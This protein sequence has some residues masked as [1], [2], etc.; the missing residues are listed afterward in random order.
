[1]AQFKSILPKEPKPNGESDFRTPRRAEA[2]QGAGSRERRDPA[3]RGARSERDRQTR[4]GQG[5]DV[6]GRTHKKRTSWNASTLGV[7][8]VIVVLLII[9]VPIVLAL[10]GAGKNLKET[11]A[12]QSSLETQRDALQ[13]SVNELRSQLDIVNTDGFIEKYAHEKLGMVRPNEILMQM[14]DG[15]VTLNESAY[16][17]YEAKQRG[18]APQGSSSEAAPEE[19]ASAAGGVSNFGYGA[20]GAPVREDP[21]VE[22]EHDAP[23]ASEENAQ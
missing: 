23:L 10:R 6:R 16:S 17:S 3:A 20:S 19:S 11:Q 9:L 4:A 21:A 8:A 14:D 15:T 22:T 12:L 18:T 5:S 7:L 1:M 2:H 13:T